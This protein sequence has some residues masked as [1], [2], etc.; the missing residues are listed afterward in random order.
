MSRRATSSSES[1]SSSFDHYFPLQYLASAPRRIGVESSSL[2]GNLYTI[3]KVG[4]AS[5]CKGIDSHMYN[6]ASSDHSLPHRT[7]RLE[8][9]ASFSATHV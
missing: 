6:I 5:L 1:P 3:E 8:C 2:I 9:A 7:L 4:I